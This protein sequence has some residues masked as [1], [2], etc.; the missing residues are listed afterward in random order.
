MFSKTPFLQA[1]AAVLLVVSL[2]W[3]MT[4]RGPDFPTL[5][6]ASLEAAN[7]GTFGDDSATSDQTMAANA[8]EELQRK[9]QLEGIAKVGDSSVIIVSDRQS[10]KIRR[11][12]AGD[13]LEGWT[14]ADS[15]ANFAVFSQEGEEARLM[16]NNEPAR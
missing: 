3:A 12:G 16:L 8:S 1:A 4:S 9:W 5:P 13:D 6:E 15:G 7:V 10:N 2:V 11:I 14:V